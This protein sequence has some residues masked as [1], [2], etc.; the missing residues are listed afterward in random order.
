MNSDRQEAA[1]RAEYASGAATAAGRQALRRK[2]VRARRQIVE[3]GGI[4]EAWRE[5]RRAARSGEAD[6]SEVREIDELRSL[7]LLLDLSVWTDCAREEQEA[8]IAV[9]ELRDRGAKRPDAETYCAEEELG[10]RFPDSSAEWQYDSQDAGRGGMLAR[11]R[12]G[13]V[14]EGRFDEL[15]EPVRGRIGARLAEAFAAEGLPEEMGRVHMVYDESAEGTLLT[16]PGL[17]FVDWGAL[18]R[19]LGKPE[20][21]RSE[22]ERTTLMGWVNR[23]V[24]MGFECAFLGL[25]RQE[26]RSEWREGG[27]KCEFKVVSEDLQYAGFEE[28]EI[29]DAKRTLLSW[30][31]PA[32][33]QH[34]MRELF[35]R[36]E[37]QADGDPAALAAVREARG[38]TLGELAADGSGDP[39][40]QAYAESVGLGV[41]MRHQVGLVD[42]I[43]SGTAGRIES[44]K[45]L[46]SR[47]ALLAGLKKAVGGEGR[48]RVGVGGDG[49]AVSS[50]KP[51][52]GAYC[53]DIGVIAGSHIRASKSNPAR[54]GGKLVG[55]GLQRAEREK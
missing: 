9:L 13:M 8:L 39:E 12:M 5:R 51:R 24:V 27:R 42:V 41:V 3:N 28:E 52:P 7:G 49:Q 30:R 32:T 45:L 1:A 31:L 17:R 48:F 26:T 21:E 53:G 22:Q 18:S 36:R 14:L 47:Q 20:A 6:R 23:R 19:M 44:R 15:P 2:A 38:S 16:R 4:P 34:A 25:V 46:V 43:V 40:I 50:T 10:V 35:G 55:V 33:R 29:A 37:R 11:Q 54:R